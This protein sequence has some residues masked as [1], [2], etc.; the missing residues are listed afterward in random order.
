MQ[1]VVKIKHTFSGLSGTDW[2]LFQL[3]GFPK[4]GYILDASY[5]LDVG[6]TAGDLEVKIVDGDYIADAISSAQFNLIADDDAVYNESAIALS[7][8]STVAV[9]TNVYGSVG[10][11]AAFSSTRVSNPG[12]LPNPYP[13]QGLLLGVRGDGV[14]AGDVIIT[15]RVRGIFS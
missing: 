6:G 11:A 15:F 8:S 1:R 13:A 2:Q 10:E 5:R 12:A 7:A 4:Q 9:N 3:D 14:L